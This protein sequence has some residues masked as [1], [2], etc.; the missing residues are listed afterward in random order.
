MQDSKDTHGQ[1][2]LNPSRLERWWWMMHNIMVINNMAKLIESNGFVNWCGPCLDVPSPSIKKSNKDYFIEVQPP[3]SF[4]DWLKISC[5]SIQSNPHESW[6]SLIYMSW[7]KFWFKGKI[8]SRSYSLYYQLQ[9]LSFKKII[10]SARFQ[11]QRKLD[12]VWLN[13][14]LLKQ[15]QEQYFQTDLLEI[16][17]RSFW[18]DPSQEHVSGEGHKRALYLE[19]I[20]MWKMWLDKWILAL[21]LCQF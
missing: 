2:L 15:C 11:W 7:F 18:E 21:F 10:S 20:W 5:W 1:S 19:I 12:K 4:G 6:M 3:W 9:G 13:L 16:G 14:L 8:F 17:W